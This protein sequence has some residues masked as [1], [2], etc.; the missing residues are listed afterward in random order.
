MPMHRVDATSLAQPLA[1]GIFVVRMRSIDPLAQAPALQRLIQNQQPSLRI[2]EVSTQA[3]LV[4]D[5]LIR[6]RLLTALGGFFAAVALLLAM[7]GLYGVLNY[8]VQ[9]R[10]RDIGIRIALGAAAFNI[11]RVVTIRVFGVVLTGTVVGVGVAEASAKYVQVLLYGMQAGAP[12]MFVLPALVLVLAALLAMIPAV[13]RA[14]RI[15]PV[16]MLRTN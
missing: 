3:E 12:S 2:S 15:D 4:R 6:E 5:Q 11:I 8:S 10:E 9:Q 13:L 14:V 7:I 1:E 16:S